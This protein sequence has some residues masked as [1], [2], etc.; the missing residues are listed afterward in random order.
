MLFSV[1]LP[2]DKQPNPQGYVLRIRSVPCRST[3]ITQ[4]LCGSWYDA[5][6][7]Y[8]DGRIFRRASSCRGTVCGFYGEE[9]KRRPI[10]VK[11]TTV[12]PRRSMCVLACLLSCFWTSSYHVCIKTRKFNYYKRHAV[13]MYL[14]PSHTNTTPLLESPFF[15]LFDF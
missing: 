9:T 11:H 14:P 13:P 5:T 8:S 2:R 4:Q 3:H 12:R 6:S 1:A 10:S 15:D 7:A